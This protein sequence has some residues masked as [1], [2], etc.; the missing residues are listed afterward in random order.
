VGSDNIEHIDVRRIVFGR[1]ERAANPHCADWN[2]IPEHSGCSKKGSPDLRP[3]W[4]LC[5]DRVINELSPELIQGD[6]HSSARRQAARLQLNCHLRPVI[7]LCR[8][9]L[10]G[11]Q[12][13]PL[14]N[15]SRRQPPDFCDSHACK[16]LTLVS[17]PSLR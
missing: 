11:F 3:C 10:G 4:R 7:L 17:A 8:A 1:N 9:D 2:S 5:E 12:R 15:I 16:M 13:R 14:L 6:A